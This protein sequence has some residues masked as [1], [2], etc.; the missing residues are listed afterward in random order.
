[1]AEKI[2]ETSTPFTP[3]EDVVM[4]ALV[5]AWNAFIKLPEQNQSAVKDFEHA[6]HEAQRVLAMRVM[7]RNYP[8]YF[9]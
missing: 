4:E 7:K 9:V 2:I 3:S 8:D 6:I 1:M 5:E